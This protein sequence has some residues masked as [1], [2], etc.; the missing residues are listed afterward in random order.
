MIANSTIQYER[1]RIRKVG[2]CIER[3]NAYENRI[4]WEKKHAATTFIF[5]EM[6]YLIE[7]IN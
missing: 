7:D 5:S 2:I 1:E 3:K 6:S 4:E